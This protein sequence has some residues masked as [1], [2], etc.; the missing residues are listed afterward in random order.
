MALVV[1]T[2]GAQESKPAEKASQE[3]TATS[4]QPEAPAADSAKQQAAAFT[5]RRDRLSYAFGVDL[6]RGIKAQ[7]INLNVDLA[8]KA[9]RDALAGEKLLMSEADATA[10]LKTY[11]EESKQDFEHAKVMISQKN[12]K[13]AEAFV[14]ENVKKEGVV[15]LPS[16]LQYKILKQ[17]KG[18][19]PTPDDQVECNY[20]GTLL[21]GTEFDSSY[22]RNQPSI[23]PVKKLIKGWS[24]A[25]QLM[26]VG[27]KWQIF[28]PP[29]LAYGERLVGGIGPNAMLTF[30]VELLDI[31][32]SAEEGHP[33]TK[34]Q[35]A[36]G[37]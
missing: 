22:K 16:G 21:D 8:V 19:K 20:R 30:D 6:A 35:A 23:L 3:T 13:A 9:L 10:A 34:D 4:P 15:T 12:K 26:P 25:L 37:K 17:G 1:A 29:H 36:T 2:S 5:S 11:E 27:S 18:R 32:P 28:I 33:V 14:A 7:R 31:K 24:E